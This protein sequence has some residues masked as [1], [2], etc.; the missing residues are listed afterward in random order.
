MRIHRSV[1]SILCCL[2][3]LAAVFRSPS[4]VFGQQVLVTASF[5]LLS[6]IST[7]P[8]CAQGF[9]AAV[10]GTVTDSSGAVV[11]KA[12]VTA[13]NKNTDAHTSVV[14]DTNGNYTVPQLQPGDY[15]VSVEAPGFK[16]GLIESL[17]LQ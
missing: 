4:S 14:T 7:S 11:A 9:T 15:Q 8:A 5:C 1:F 13:I 2:N 10:L 16:R 6:A 12:I 17:T 3:R